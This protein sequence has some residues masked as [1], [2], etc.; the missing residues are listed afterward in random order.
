MEKGEGF[1]IG[2][3]SL[4]YE[5][6]SHTRNPLTEDIE[7]QL[8][9]YRKG[10]E[11]RLGTMWPV[12]KVYYKRPDQQRTTE[13]AIRSTLREDLYVLYEGMGQDEA[14][15]FTA[16][17]NPL[18]AWVWIGAWVVTFGMVVVIWPDRREEVRRRRLAGVPGG[19]AR[20][21]PA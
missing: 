14:A 10:T 4:V 11:E 13:V 12:Q 15:F 8:G 2:G 9:V 20:E 6:Y 21:V 7:T 1:D 5:G 3:Y 19:V 18:V 17:I 16:Y